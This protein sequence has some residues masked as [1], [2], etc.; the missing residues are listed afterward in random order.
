MLYLPHKLP[1]GLKRFFNP[2]EAHG[3]QGE[4]LRQRRDGSLSCWCNVSL[5]PLRAPRDPAGSDA[6]GHLIQTEDTVSR[7]AWPTCL[8]S[9]NTQE[10]HTEVEFKVVCAV[11]FLGLSF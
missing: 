1:R 10:G 7:D 3:F 8:P 11:L 6:E 4:K 5:G 9:L 2:Q